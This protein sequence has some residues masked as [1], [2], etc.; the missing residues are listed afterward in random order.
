MLKL[1]M[2]L[3]PHF[4]DKEKEECLPI[5]EMIIRL[6][7]IARHEGLL[8]MENQISD[9]DS[10]FL[11]KAIMLI[12][13]GSNPELIKNI[14]QTQILSGNHTGF[15][16]LSRLIMLE[17]CLCVQDGE[18]PRIIATK[19]G[20]IMG[21]KYC[22]QAVVEWKRKVLKAEAERFAEWRRWLVEEEADDPAREC[23]PLEIML[24]GM[25][26]ASIQRLGNELEI[27]TIAS[28]MEGWRWRKGA[29]AIRIIVRCMPESQKQLVWEAYKDLHCRMVKE[30]VKKII[31]KIDELEKQGVIALR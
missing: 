1:I 11:K 8:S 23:S 17:G 3:K 18:N 14:M 24:R 15:E 12:V 4:T 7:N 2:R 5:I 20:A 13:D 16:L 9:L 19:L 26:E 22:L 30:P 31:K 28:A 27:D 21:E 29:P 25:P 10:P 6:A